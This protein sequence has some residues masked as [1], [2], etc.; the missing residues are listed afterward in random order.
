[1]DNSPGLSSE[2]QQVKL[3]QINYDDSINKDDE[4]ARK[5]INYIYDIMVACDILKFEK[6]TIS[7]NAVH[8]AYE[9]QIDFK[10]DFHIFVYITLETCY[11][12]NIEMVKHIIE[13]EIM[14]NI[15]NRMSIIKWE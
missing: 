1:M 15:V 13:R 7:F 2:W 11:A 5:I 4:L 12:N 14:R 9:I 10:N 8:F 3:S 6:C